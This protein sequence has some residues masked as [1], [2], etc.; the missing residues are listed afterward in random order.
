MIYKIELTEEIMKELNSF[1]DFSDIPDTDYLTPDWIEGYQS[2][3]SDALLTLGI[4]RSFL[5]S[6]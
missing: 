4:D 2:G 5:K 6:S 3:L 1:Y